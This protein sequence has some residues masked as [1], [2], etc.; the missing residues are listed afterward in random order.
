MDTHRAIWNARFEKI[1]RGERRLESDP[2]LE[3]W[4]H[5]APQGNRRRALDIGCGCGHNAKLLADRGFEVTGMDISDRALELCRREVPGA[6]VLCAD[7]GEGLPFPPDSF[8]LI[9]ADLSLHYFPWHTT[10]AIVRD[11]AN[12]LV[13]CGLFAGRFNSINDRN[14]GAETG[15]AVPDEPNL[16][17]VGGVEKRF[18]TRQCFARLFGAPWRV[19]GM[20][21]KA[22][23]RF[24]AR[25]IL[26]EFAAVKDTRESAEQGTPGDADKPRR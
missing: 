6:R 9:V 21:E 10:A 25:K 13:T 26:W 2:W 7:V 5:M 18:F 8:E 12:C 4:L 24:G 22:T 20:G 1:L 11:M 19:I 23:D 16:L 17:V 15:E 14:Y 3:H